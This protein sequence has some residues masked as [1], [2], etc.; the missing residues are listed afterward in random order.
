MKSSAL[1]AACLVTV[2]AGCK[3][4]GS[5]SA[6]R[7]DIGA[8][9][10]G[11]L[12]CAFKTPNGTGNAMEIWAVP[13]AAQLTNVRDRYNDAR[14]GAEPMRQVGNAPKVDSATVT[15]GGKQDMRTYFKDLS[16][17]DFQKY[18]CYT[19]GGS[20]GTGYLCLASKA[21]G[22]RTDALW[23]TN[24]G[25]QTYREELTIYGAQCTKG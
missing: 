23:V 19:L 9:N 15:K 16:Q 20:K 1:L 17:I 3:T 4:G 2:I 25:D 7:S 8:A 13:G 18:S 14:D 10:D 24:Y 6:L 11:S 12:Y 22:D 5:Q 21:M